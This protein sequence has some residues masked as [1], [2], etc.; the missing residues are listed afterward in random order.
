[1]RL[2]RVLGPG[3]DT[4]ELVPVLHRTYAERNQNSRRKSMR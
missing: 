3:F 1:M 4:E 2:G